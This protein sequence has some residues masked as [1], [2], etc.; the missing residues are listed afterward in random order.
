MRALTIMFAVAACGGGL[1][2]PVGDGGPDDAP[3]GCIVSITHETVPPFASPSTFVRAVANVQN[4]P[5]QHTYDWAVVFNTNQLLPFTF[6]APDMSAIRFDAVN[7]GVYRVRYRVLEDALCSEATA[8][9]EIQPPDAS[10]TV[11]RVHVVAPPDLG[12]PPFDKQVPV[13]NEATDTLED[14]QLPPAAPASGV[15]SI[16]G[17]P[18]AA[19]LKFMP[20]VGSDA[21]V[22]T[23]SDT[24]GN[25]TAAIRGEPHSVLV[26]PN[27]QTGV[28]PQ[29]VSWTP[30]QSSIALSQG[31]PAS[32]VVANAQGTGI[33]NAT[34]Q[35]TVDGVPST[36]GTTDNGGNFA[37]FT[38]AATGKV[39]IEVTPPAN[40]GL[41]RLVAE[42]AA[43][44]VGSGMTVAYANLTTRDLAGTRIE[45]GAGN[46]LG[47]ATVTIVGSV[48]SAGTITGSS[49][50]TAAG[51]T[52][53]TAVTNG[54]GVLPTL[55]V[56]AAP[57][58]AVVFPAGAAGDHALTAIDLTASV[59]ATINA[60]PT[61]AKA[62]QLTSFT[63]T[64]LLGAIIDAVPTGPLALAGAPTI[65]RV[66]G[67]NG[68]LTI[69]LAPTATYDIRLSDPNGNRGALEVLEDRTTA[70]LPAVNALGKATVAK[71]TVIGNGVIPGAIVQ[72]LCA[73]PDPKCTG[74]ERSRPI[75]EGVT[76]I[77]GKFS[78]AVPDPN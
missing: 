51:E 22:E 60:A 62:T 8:E 12:R 9:I 50:L 61:T 43:F 39:R 75:A 58:H 78:L 53:F 38:H 11:F 45:R 32:G 54:S 7:A 57:L 36:I 26:V 69:N 65:R 40:L 41:P 24:L 15:V 71:A 18:V 31:V 49:A 28:P 4:S 30:G 73:D 27:A 33:A 2:G 48:A 19:Y 55:R 14:I 67:A 23:Y 3:P 42:A 59:P 35:I 70:T 68:N 56:P 1:E 77:D 34:V 13:I 16:D 66:A 17:A 64:G 47:N 37:V 72:F 52:R 76:G 74:L 6:D 46:G 63:G 29:L 44:T 10:S 25:Y 20:A 21:I 5:G